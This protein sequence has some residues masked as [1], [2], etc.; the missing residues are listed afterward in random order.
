VSGNFDTHFVKKHFSPEKLEQGNEEEAKIA[1]ML[2][3]ELLE[4]RQ[5]SPKLN[6]TSANIVQIK[7]NWKNRAK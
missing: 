4:K 5:K 7:S 1:A 3:A 6:S 2:V